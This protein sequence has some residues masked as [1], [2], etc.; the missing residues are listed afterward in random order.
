MEIPSHRIKKAIDNNGYVF[1]KSHSVDDECI[2]AIS[3]IGQIHTVNNSRIKQILVPL[4]NEESTPNTYSGNYGL[5]SFPMHTDLAHWKEPPRYFALRCIDG[6][7]TVFTNMIDSKYLLSGIDK[8]E[9]R[10]ILVQPRRPIEG[11]RPLL[12]LLDVNKDGVEMFRWDPLFIEPATAESKAK[13]KNILNL[14]EESLK[15][16]ILLENPGDTLIVD[17]WRMLHGR[18][19]VSEKDIKRKIERVYMS[20]LLEV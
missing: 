17:N 13:F 18:S 3:K 9:L 14:I 4:E 1:L 7:K 12:S 2:Q 8:T 11:K 5:N 15:K 10:R 16:S 19:S 6:S 20:E